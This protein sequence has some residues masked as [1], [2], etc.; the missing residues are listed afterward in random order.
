MCPFCIATT[1]WI[2]AGATSASGVGALALTKLLRSGTGAEDF[3]LRM[4]PEGEE[5]GS[6]ENRVA[7]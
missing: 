4:Q 1:A 6:P 7:G 5:D 3:Q 2:V